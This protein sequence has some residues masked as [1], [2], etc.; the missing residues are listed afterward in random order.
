MF[1][2]RVIE[3]YASTDIDTMEYI[4]DT[5]ALIPLNGAFAAIEGMQCML[6]PLSMALTFPTFM[7]YDGTVPRPEVPQPK[8]PTR[9]PSIA[10]APRLTAADQQAAARASERAAEQ[11]ASDMGAEAVDD[12]MRPDTIKPY[13]GMTGIREDLGAGPTPPGDDERRRAAITKTPYKHSP[14]VDR[15]SEDSELN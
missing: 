3:H 8:D 2:Y 15:M 11:R 4:E 13:H 14:D 7:G 1:A 12:A 6:V 10:D 5:V 9:L